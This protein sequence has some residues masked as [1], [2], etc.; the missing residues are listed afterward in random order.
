MAKFYFFPAPDCLARRAPHFGQAKPFQGNT[1]PRPPFESVVKER[2]GR[3]LELQPGLTSFLLSRER[4][5][6]DR[7]K[8]TVL[9]HIESLRAD[10]GLA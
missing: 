5:D 9:V 3:S 7:E 1:R 2:G 10:L 6:C 8:E 4:I